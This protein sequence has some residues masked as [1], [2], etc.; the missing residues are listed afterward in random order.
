[1]KQD[2]TKYLELV[3]EPIKVCAKYKPKFGQGAKGDGLT[4][5]QFQTLYQS[6]PFY[7]WFGLDNPMMYAAHK[8]AG[9]MTSVYRQIG[10]GC[11]KLFRAILMGSLELTD[12]DVAWSYDIPLPNG[13]TRTLHLDG[14]IPLEKIPDKAKRYRFHSWMK[15]SADAIGVDRKVFSNLTGTVFEVRQGYK[16]KDS[17]RQNADIANAATAYTKAYLPCAVI[18]STQIDSDILLRYRAEK[19]TVITGIEGAKNPLISTYDFMRDVIGYDLAA[20]FMRNSKTLRIEIDTVLKALLTP[21][22]K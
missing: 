19:W 13:K 10:I 2:D 4:L 3:L 17:K 15:D 16:S 21:E 1:M 18:L 5:A 14:R 22:T 11:E 20:F 12:A 9:G 6:D 7:S 8:A